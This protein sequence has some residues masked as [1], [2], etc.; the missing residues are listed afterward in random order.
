MS[1]QLT[2]KRV[3]ANATST[4]VP[5]AQPG[6]GGQAR[7]DSGRSAVIISALGVAVASIAT[8]VSTCNVRESLKLTRESNEMALQHNRLS[9]RPKLEVS[10]V[11]GELFSSTG[12]E[13]I[14]VTLSNR[15][16]GPADVRWSAVSLDGVQQHS[17]HELFVA[18]GGR[19][20]SGTLYQLGR[21]FWLRPDAQQVLIREEKT[22]S[23]RPFNNAI[24][25]GRITF[26]FCFCSIYDECWMTTA[27]N[28]VH[29]GDILTK[30][31]PAEDLQFTAP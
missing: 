30:Q 4:P 20:H 6:A 26:N 13:G 5:G 10:R 15:G 27:R 12:E 8:I 14:S 28:A 9:V 24:N 7:R 25:Q 22:D 1:K 29:A 17:W 16:L 19:A 2:G 3:S 18:L 23:A 11:P 31:C 21:S